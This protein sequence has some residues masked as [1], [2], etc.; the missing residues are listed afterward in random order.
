[1]HEYVHWELTSESCNKGKLPKKNFYDRYLLMA[2]VKR[3]VN[4]KQFY[5]REISNNFDRYAM[6]LIGNS[7]LSDP[8]HFWSLPSTIQY[9]QSLTASYAHP[10]SIS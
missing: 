2:D 6:L 1:M 9:K 5:K 10:E 3:F 4:V 8:V 7:K